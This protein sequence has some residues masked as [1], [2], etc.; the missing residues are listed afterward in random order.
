MI[1]FW[2]EPL[3]V[4]VDQLSRALGLTIIVSSDIP[5]GEVHVLTE[6]NQGRRSTRPLIKNIGK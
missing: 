5:D 1:K 6:D 2:D 3:P 4:K